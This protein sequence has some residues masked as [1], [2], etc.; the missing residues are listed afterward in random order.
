MSTFHK[1]A[2]NKQQCDRKQNLRS[3]ENVIEYLLFLRDQRES[4]FAFAAELAPD[5]QFC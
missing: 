5:F 3:H 2:A 1:M 4:K